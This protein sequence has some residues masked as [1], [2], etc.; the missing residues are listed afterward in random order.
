VLAWLDAD[1]GAARPYV[2]SLLCSGV[3]IV[4][5]VVV[6]I[7]DQRF[8]ALAD[9]VPKAIS[10]TLFDAGH[11]HELHLFLEHH[12]QQL[13]EDEKA[14]VLDIIRRLPLPDRGDNSERIRLRIQ[15]NWLKPIAGQGY[16]PADTWLADLNKALGTS[17][18]FVPPDFNRYHEMRWGFGPTPHEAQEL[19]AFAQAGK[20]SSIA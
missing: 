17:A 14:A 6:H 18:M 4:E 11:R 3:E 13:T 15:Q 1:A 20:P 9:L 19:V 12:F 8:Q 5:R 16:E 7:L 2:E 10:P